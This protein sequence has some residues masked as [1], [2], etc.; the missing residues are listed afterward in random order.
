MSNRLRNFAILA[1]IDAG[2]TTLSERI[3]FAAGEIRHPGDVEDGLATMDYL[4][5]EK[6][7]GI[8]IEAGVAHFEWRE[9]W[10]NFID[11]PGHIDFGA[12][13]DMA[14]TAVDGAVLVVSAI[15]GVQTQAQTGWKKLQSQRVRTLLYVNKLDRPE[16]HLD[17]V[18]ME[19]EE[20][21]GV[22][23]LLLSAPVFADGELIGSYDVLSDSVLVHDE[24]GLEV[25]AADHL[26]LP[27]L[28]VLRR[29]AIEAAATVDDDLLELALGDG[30]VAPSDLL[31]G[32]AKLAEGGEYVLC[33][34]GSALRNRGVRQLLNGLAFFLP[35]APTLSSQR[36]GQVVRLRH[37]QGSGEVAL[38]RSSADLPR[39]K[40][41]AGIEFYRM[42]A[43]M[44]VPVESIRAQD[45]YALRS[46]VENLQLGMWLDLKGKKVAG[47]AE[48]WHERYTPLLQTRI[49]C[50]KLDDWQHIDD[51]LN[52]LSRMD[53]SFRVAVDPMGG[54]W[55]LSTVGEVQLEVLLARL[56]REFHCDVLAGEPDVQWHERLVR[57]LGPLVNT[58]QAGP[59]AVSVEL[60]VRP[61][62][63]YGK[64]TLVGDC[65]NGDSLEILAAVRAAL[66]EA[67][68]AGVLGKGSLHGVEFQ[69][70]RLEFG[71]APVP[72]VK[73]ACADAVRLLIAAQDVELYEPY[74][75]LELECPTQYA[76]NVTGDLQHRD[77][78]VR[79]IGGDG[80]LHR[81]VAEMPLRKAFGYATQVR[82]ITRG[83][84]SYSLRYLEHR[85]L[86]N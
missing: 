76:G 38:F 41:P 49:E 22:R 67:A 83:T 71:E 80:R 43:Q 48:D 36:L 10:F 19:I 20:V 45:I 46:S 5:E 26:S 37:F 15:E 74:M 44:L 63:E 84:A 40:W 30:M 52:L 56:S 7:R 21:L 2:K 18:L 8:T 75:H 35:D 50:R 28:Q 9:T 69:I 23:P 17:D 25:V 31:R 54:Y 58:F 66:L 39:K 27:T 57:P 65:L 64:C 34:A 68:D 70:H 78:R 14:L 53:P 29:E 61:L 13:V 12:E 60:S 24:H 42:T 79:E 55:L 16:Q 72:M 1:H 4:P 81:M 32:L 86:K 51:S 73:K 77:G 11:T 6:E 59:F 33:Y 82:S 3:L 62:A 85:V 47:H